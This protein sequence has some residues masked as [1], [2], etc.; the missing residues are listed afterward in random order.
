TESYTPPFYLWY[1][2][3][4]I[5]LTTTPGKVLYSDGFIDSGGV[6]RLDIHRWVPGRHNRTRQ[7]D[8]DTSVPSMSH[9]AFR[10]GSCYVVQARVL[11]I[12]VPCWYTQ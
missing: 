7:A 1:L 3:I 2:V 9:G 8:V 6:T 10:C 4:D 11:D 5:P 12:A